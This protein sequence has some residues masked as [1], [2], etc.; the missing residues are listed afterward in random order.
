[1]NKLYGKFPHGVVIL[2][3]N[4]KLNSIKDEYAFINVQRE[5]YTMHLM[6]NLSHHLRKRT[7]FSTQLRKNTG[8]GK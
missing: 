5:D 7:P 4:S 2:C 6:Q 1:M 8:K 3:T